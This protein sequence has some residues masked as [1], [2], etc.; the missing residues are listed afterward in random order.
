MF[1]IKLSLFAEGLTFLFLW[2]WNK[3]IELTHA[4]TYASFVSLD[5]FP[6]LKILANLL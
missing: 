2:I 3:S 1:L 4:S 5:S 6:I